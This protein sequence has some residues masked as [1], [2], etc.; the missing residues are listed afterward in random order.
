MMFPLGLSIEC[1]SDIITPGYPMENSLGIRS[2]SR[3]PTSGYQE[4]FSLIL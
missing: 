4:G 3:E 2:F 1:E